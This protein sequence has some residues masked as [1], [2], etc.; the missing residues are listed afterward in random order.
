ML[1]PYTQGLSEKFK[2][3]ENG[4]NIKSFQNKKFHLLRKIKLKSELRDNHSAYIIILY[5]IIYIYIILYTCGAEY[6]GETIRS[7]GVRIREHIYNIMQVYFDRPNWLHIE[8][9]QIDW[10]QTDVLMLEPNN[11][12]R[13]YEDKTHMYE[14]PY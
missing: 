3:I 7:L 4:F 6:N 11:I 2:I 13:K 12:Y 9:Q 10:N 8:Y 1:I 14:Q 5:Y